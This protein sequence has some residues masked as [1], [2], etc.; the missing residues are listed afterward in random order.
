M[1]A[2]SPELSP[3][4]LLLEYD[5]LGPDDGLWLNML[6]ECIANRPQRYKDELRELP[7]YEPPHVREGPNLAFAVST[8]GNQLYR[9]DDVTEARIADS[10]YLKKLRSEDTSDV[11]PAVHYSLQRRIRVYRMG[12][13][14][15]RCLEAAT[16]L[17]VVP[18]EEATVT[19][20][21][22][23]QADALV[24]EHETVGANSLSAA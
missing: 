22:P 20:I 1:S 8:R 3:P 9:F 15:D 21:M 18:V 2:P 14:I 24:P 7:L 19:A 17:E 10:E 12:V 5:V 11:H 16:V 6:A 4:R 23:T 13:F